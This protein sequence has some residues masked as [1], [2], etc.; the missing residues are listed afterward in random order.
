[1]ILAACL[2]DELGFVTKAI[3]ANDLLC[4]SSSLAFKTQGQRHTTSA[5]YK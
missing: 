1:M 4:L 3:E 5:I 2:I